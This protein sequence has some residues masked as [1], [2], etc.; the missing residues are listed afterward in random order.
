MD[1]KTS[2]NGAELKKMAEEIRESVRREVRKSLDEVRKDPEKERSHKNG[3]PYG[4][5]AAISLELD[6][7]FGSEHTVSEKKN[8]DVAGSEDFWDLG[9][10]KER[11]YAPPKFS[12][13]SLGVTDVTDGCDRDGA[14]PV[15]GQEKI[16]DTAVQAEKI[17]P[18]EAYNFR[19]SER[20][21][22]VRV[23]NTVDGPRAFPSGQSSRVVTSSYKRKP[24]VA[25]SRQDY[26]GG[27]RKPAETVKT[28]CPEGILI[29]EVNVKT[30]ESDTEFYGRFASDAKRS[31]ASPAEIPWNTP[32]ESVPY[33]SYVPQYAHMNLSQMNFYRHLRENIRHGSYPDCDLAYIQLYIFEIVNLPDVIPPEEG[34]EILAGVWMNYRRRHPRLDSFLCEWLA[35]YCLIGGCP[36][37]E[38]VG[39]ILHEIVPKA[40]FKEFYL[41]TLGNDSTDGL[42]RTVLEVSSDYDYRSG[43]YYRDHE[44]AYNELIPRA[45]GCVMQ[46]AKEEGRGIFAMDRV[47]RMTRDSYSGAIVSSGIKRRIDIEFL[48]F[49]RRADTREIVTAIAKYAENRLRAVLGIKAKLGADKISPEDMAVIDA[50]FE[51]LLP[52]TTKKSAEEK[53]MP[54]DY[55]KNYESEDSGFDFAAAQA[56]EAQSWINTSRLT[57]D[58]SYSEDL[59]AVPEYEADEPLTLSGEMSTEQAADASGADDTARYDTP[60]D[61]ERGESAHGIMPVSDGEN[62]AGDSREDAGGDSQDEIRDAL[63]AA[64]M[65]EFRLYCRRN[66]LYEGEA[67]D[68]VNNIFLDEIGDVVLENTGS[69][70]ELVEDY[71]EDVVNWLR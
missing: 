10:P 31:H 30:W 40:Q 27:T 5:E 65:G 62:S 36:L 60:A 13:S 21:G 52:K 33:F 53:Y 15:G 24:P 23:R 25:Q 38:T 17:L 57:G 47:Y 69:G 44:D 7:N 3:A 18:R 2:K 61:T 35:D 42:G 71:R 4:A 55:M 28:Y 9:K 32:M 45:V 1:D 14:S 43:R 37:P 41:N 16:R 51:P 64:L 8:H 20:S 46:K 63:Q 49:T 67:A 12:E 59:Q 68:R 48:S 50:F 29:R 11:I 70:F 39:P 34:A 6:V 19:D 22:S 66:N 54:A 56:I 26:P 58:D